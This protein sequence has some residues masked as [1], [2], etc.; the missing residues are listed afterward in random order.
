MAAGID[1]DHY[2]ETG[3]QKPH[4]MKVPCSC[5]LNAMKRAENPVIKTE[6]C[7]VCNR[8]GFLREELTVYWDG[9]NFESGGVKNRTEIKW[10][11]NCIPQPRRK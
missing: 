1:I 10:C 5:V 8:K 9:P 6:D 4:L 11:P 2:I 7:E 3:I